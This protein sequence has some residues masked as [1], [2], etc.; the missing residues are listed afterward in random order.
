MTSNTRDTDNRDLN[1]M[2][3]FHVAQIEVLRRELEKAK[4][5]ISRLE[6][7][8]NTLTSLIDTLTDK[9]LRPGRLVR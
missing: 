9:L 1:E 3:R 4:A 2:E 7:L 6:S 5:E 8:I